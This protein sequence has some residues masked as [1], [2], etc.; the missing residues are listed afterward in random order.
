VLPGPVEAAVLLFVA[1]EGLVFVFVGDD[2]WPVM[3]GWALAAGGVWLAARAVRSSWL[4]KALAVLLVVAC[5]ALAT[6]Q[7]LYLLPAALSLLVA[8]FFAPRFGGLRPPGKS[9]GD[10]EPLT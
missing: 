2:A 6:L 10:S 9:L 1:A 8:A 3:L 7:G 5:L 4:R